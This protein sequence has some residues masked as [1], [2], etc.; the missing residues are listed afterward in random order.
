MFIPAIQIRLWD[1]IKLRLG[2]YKIPFLSLL[3][4][5]EGNIMGYGEEYKLGKDNH[6]HLPFNIKDVVENI[7][8]K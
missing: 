4:R 7:K 5:G 8:I 6:Y 2:V 1:P 3:G